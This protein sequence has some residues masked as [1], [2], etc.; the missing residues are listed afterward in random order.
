[1]IPT[2]G[3]SQELI[4]FRVA[5][6]V[7][8]LLLSQ[9]ARADDWPMWRY[10]ANRSAA[11]PEN[12]PDQLHLQW[13]K[14]F[15]SPKPAWPDEP[16]LDFDRSYEPVVMGLT[17]FVPSMVNDSVTAL[18]IRTGDVKWRFPTGGPVRFAP[19]AWNNKVYV[20]SD[21]GFLYCLDANKGKLL[22]KFRGAP[23]AGK[24]LG[25]GRLISTWPARG[26]PVLAD[27]TVYF[28]AG[29]WPFMGVFLYAL[30][31]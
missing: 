25:N 21:D 27:G 31:A 14:E 26:G 23:A 4:A 15:P 5:M 29:I 17:M 13:I 28:A 3:S 30:D 18:D 1:M 11:S 2:S 10:D 9:V 22:W 24:V 19:A 12:L 20:V 7:T 8:T 16:K 6:V